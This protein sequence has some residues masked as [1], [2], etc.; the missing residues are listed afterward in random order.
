M[1]ES[2]TSAG[3]SSTEMA[4]AEALA[5]VLAPPTPAFPERTQDVGFAD[6]L[7]RFLALLSW[8]DRIGIRLY[9][10]LLDWLPRLCFRSFRRLSQ[11]DVEARRRFMEGMADSR[12]LFVRLFAKVALLLTLPPFYA[13]PALRAK[14]GDR[15]QDR[16]ATDG[17]EFP[18]ERAVDVVRSA[19]IL[20]VD[21]VVVGSGAGGAPLACELAERGRSVLV[22][23]EG[24]YRPATTFP[25]LAF[26]AL[27]QL[28]RDAGAV[29]TL[30][31]PPVV[32]PVGRLVG[33][34]TVI[35]SGTCFRIPEFV[36][37]HWTDDLGLPESLS[38]E[39]LAP[40]FARVEDRIS[41]QPV[42][43][44][45]LGPNNEVAKR[46]S[47]ALGWSGGF[48][49]RNIRGCKGSNRCAFG[50]PVN[51]KQAMHLCYLPDAV[52][53]GARVLS[54]ARVER[55]LFDGKAACGVRA[56]VTD[57]DGRP[58][59]LEVRARAVVVSAGTLYTP[60]L[61]RS[62]GIRHR[63]LGR[64]LTLHPAVKISGLFPGADF[65][66]APSVPQSWYVD[67]FHKK[68]IM[69]EG[70]HVPPDVAAPALPGKGAEHKAL[71]E[72]YREIAT[73]GFLV[74]DQPAGRIHRRLGGRPFI[75]YDLTPRDHGLVLFGLKRLVELF[76]AAGAEEVYMPVSRLPVI[77]RG[78]D[79]EALIDAA[80]IRPLDLEVAAFHPLG[81]CGFG[82]D[83]KT[84]VLDT[85]LKVRGREGLYV[86]DG[87]MFPTSLA[88]N[89]QES[90]MALATRCA[91]HL[92]EVVLPPAQG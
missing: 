4:V 5:E 77:R 12:V 81:T 8:E 45:V 27:A 46:G 7:N 74:S 14:I 28:Y 42:D 34:T 82:V 66:T 58:H 65:L 15:T 67:E 63:N 39:A 52:Q 35:N 92:D 37:R 56:R 72:R 30:G 53:A 36:H 80:D 59:R 32:V 69:M 62:S 19:E 49:A 78:E 70:A 29:M 33:G 90:I 76:F 11:L 3:L 75:R 48:L 87:S 68:G 9:L 10:R 79:Y 83:G 71:M 73:Y 47:E 55:V 38:Q 23:E 44:A 16:V 51:A 89:P 25:A 88:V 50:C 54:G 43:P 40:L 91:W 1:A 17:R 13:D 2:G 64:R 41:V 6:R 24:E 86:A 22:L 84:F 85:D 57:E 21:V 20:D 26:E 31:K 61:L 60:L 18:V